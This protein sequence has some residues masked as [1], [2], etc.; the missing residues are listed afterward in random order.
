VAGSYTYNPDQ[1]WEY[2]AAFSSLQRTSEDNLAGRL[3][4]SRNI[5]NWD[6]FVDGAFTDDQ[7]LG[8]GSAVGAG[9]FYNVPGWGG[10]FF[11][12]DVTEDF[13]PRIGFAAE[14]DFRG[15]S[16]GV[17]RE[18]EYESGAITSAEFGIEAFDYTRRDGAHYRE[19][20][21]AGGGFAFRNL[22]AVDFG[23]EYEHFE[24]DH[25]RTFG[26]S[27]E[28]PYNN[29]Y[30]SLEAGIVFG[31]IE[32]TTYRSIE[33]GFR[34]RPVQR[35]Q[36]GLSAQAV[37]HVEDEEQIVFNFNYL[38]NKFESIGGRVVYNEHEW[39]WYASYRM[40]GNAGAE[41]FLIVGDPNASSF[42]K[43]LVF[44]VSVPFTIG[45]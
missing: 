42:Q 37:K 36:L 44:K 27:I 6:A 18:I 5:G 25:N 17:D 23:F 2:T 34:Y 9:M 29:P 26:T 8:T 39:N 30:R 20:V 28:Y 12:D 16:T 19:G 41:F 15:F 33:A 21:G 38:M 22:I 11:Y 13:F 4:I 1:F 32:G 40:G 43:T 7:V 14:T 3:N 10:R 24:A 31:E 35:L 45:W